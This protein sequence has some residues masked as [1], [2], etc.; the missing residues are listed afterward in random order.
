MA[1]QITSV[2]DFADFRK[3]LDDYQTRRQAQD[4]SFTRSKFCRDLGLPNTRS[5]FNDIVKGTRSLSKTYIERFVMALNMND[6]EAQY[7]RV[8]VDFNQSSIPRER[9]LLFDQLVSLNS[10]PARLVTPDEYEF[11]RHWHHTTIFSLLDILDFTDDYMALA[12]RIFPAITAAEAKESIA[13]LR[14]LG[15]IHKTADGFWKPTT[16]TL[17]TGSYVKGEL[18]RQY[19]LQCLDLSKRAM[20]LEHRAP[21]NFSTVTL[22]VSKAGCELIEKKLQKF[23]SEARS[24][25]HREAA[26]ADRVYQLNI[27]FFPQ[28]LPETAL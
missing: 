27:Q 19:Q 18:V 23:K 2:F 22:S 11:Y 15:L 26:P 28:S 9:E 24:I 3:F 12:K 6:N 10:T 21:R 16:K 1:P 4:K 20:L 13:L 7:F 14:K 5:F 8:L 17:D 25:A